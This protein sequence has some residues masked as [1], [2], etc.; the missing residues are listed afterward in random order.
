MKSESGL[1]TASSIDVS[2]VYDKA[3]I[4]D[5]FYTVLCFEY[6]EDWETVR[7][8]WRAILDLFIKHKDKINWAGKNKPDNNHRL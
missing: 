5:N 3:W 6:I 7:R 8:T 2:T 4:R 1:F